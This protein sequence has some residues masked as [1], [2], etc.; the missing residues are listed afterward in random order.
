MDKKHKMTTSVDIFFKELPASANAIDRVSRP[1]T[2]SVASDRVDDHSKISNEKSNGSNENSYD[3]NDKSFSD[4][5]NDQSIDNKNT[6]TNNTGKENPSETSTA[7]NQQQDVSTQASLNTQNEEN[8]VI[9]DNNQN[10][11]ATKDRATNNS[12]QPDQN[13]ITNIVPAPVQAQTNDNKG[14][15]QTTMNDGQNIKAADQSFTI[16]DVKLNEKLPEKAILMANEHSVIQK[17]VVNPLT[18]PEIANI[19]TALSENKTTTNGAISQNTGQT[20]GTS[21]VKTTSKGKATGDIKDI[22]T[23]I[24]KPSENNPIITANNAAPLGQE[25]KTAIEA[26]KSSS[27]TVTTPDNVPV[28]SKGVNDGKIT[29]GLVHENGLGQDDIIK[30]GN[31]ITNTAALKSAPSAAPAMDQNVVEQNN[32]VP[33]EI[34]NEQKAVEIN[35]PLAQ[36]ASIIKTDAVNPEKLN[37]AANAADISV[38]AVKNAATAANPTTVINNKNGGVKS[39]ASIENKK[40][41]NN[42]A[43]SNAANGAVQTQQ[44]NTQQTNLHNT[45][46]SDIFINAGL[47][48]QKAEQILPQQINLTGQS[49]L[50]ANNIIAAQEMNIQKSAAQLATAM[51]TETAT[52]AKMVSEQI[53]VTITKNILKGQNNFSIRLNPADL[54]QVDVRLEFMADGK[55]HAALMVENEKTLAMLQRDQSAL[56][57]ALQNT[58]LDLSQSNL[59]FSLMKKEDQNNG[60]QFA[61]TNNSNGNDQNQNELAQVSSAQEMRMQYSDQTIDIS[62]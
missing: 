17:V 32:G 36:A 57:K 28:Q 18:V 2:K 31:N 20:N 46:K 33:S 58:G 1:D 60:Q 40:G 59:N 41:S 29:S 42:S 39:N 55:V 13:I 24:I 51:K 12:T 49:S 52:H 56:E 14:H 43:S 45:I 47:T 53:S 16:R 30:D 9:A 35:I 62:V 5:L 27:Q 25:I 11:A 61:G 10:I 6:E 19:N 3:K 8:P 21:E 54:G 37:P 23:N 4:H 48:G 34:K 50:A 15:V 26:V 7:N 44:S 38:D 22:I